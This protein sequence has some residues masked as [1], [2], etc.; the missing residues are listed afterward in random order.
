MK[1]GKGFG[2]IVSILLLLCLSIGAIGAYPGIYSQTVK[3]RK[4]YF[5]EENFTNQLVQ[6]S[7]A[8]YWKMEQQKADK[9]LLP[10]DVFMPD[11]TAPKK[12]EAYRQGVTYAGEYSAGYEDSEYYE[13]YDEYEEERAR[14]EYEAYD[15]YQSFNGWFRDIYETMGRNRGMQF[16]AQDHKTNQVLSNMKPSQRDALSP[17]TVLPEFD[18]QYQ[19]Y[20]WLTFDQKGEASISQVAGASLESQERLKAMDLE[21]LIYDYNWY[22]FMNYYGRMEGPKDMSLL[23]AVENDNNAYGSY[24]WYYG[25]WHERS[26]FY[27]AGFAWL[28]LGLCGL[29]LLLGLLLPII[30]PLRLGGGVSR[31][32]PLEL[33]AFGLLMVIPFSDPMVQMALSTASG[34]AYQDLLENSFLPGSANVL[35]FGGNLT[36][37]MLLL[38]AIYLMGLSLRQI[39]TMG[40]KAYLLKRCWCVRFVSWCCRKVKGLFSALG[41]VDLSEKSNKM[42]AK[43]VFANFLILTLI[44]CFWFFGVAGLVIYS[45]I[46]YVVLKSRLDEAKNSYQKLMDQIRRMK[47]G[48]LDASTDEDLG[49][50]EPMKQELSGLADGMARAVEV[51][52]ESQRTTS[53]MINHAADSL[54]EPLKD[55]VDSA[56]ALDGDHTPEEW[57]A[58]AAGVME[59]AA[60]L[61][62]VID[63]LKR[64]A[65]AA[66]KS[67]DVSLEPVDLGALLKQAEVELGDQATAAGIAL[68]IQ[69]P[70]EKV[71]LPLDS[72]KSYRVIEILFKNIIKHGQPG[73]RAYV[74][75][76]PMEDW[77]E[78]TLKNTSAKELDERAFGGEAGGLN[79]ALAK[80]LTELMDGAYQVSTDGDL[81]KTVLRFK[82]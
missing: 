37:W 14:A 5:E 55:L 2:V 27:Q 39:F 17:G 66:A 12:P 50:F 56:N 24:G 64:A 23:L 45:L 61:Q 49:V 73:S 13:Y 82:R 38:G 31:V 42:L 16:W 6:S 69:L 68:R 72:D 60:R 65:T 29:V 71:I 20:I 35:V 46:L 58:L 22:D 79:V 15:R 26:N 36:A 4:N 54:Q 57:K 34:A 67:G 59:K 63:S 11:Y 51:E 48:R 70:E 28:Y 7:Y 62:P 74:T 21:D 19:Y 75:V 25:Y 1:R 8:I 43:A 76:K 18:Q 77:V 10:T 41:Q 30:K 52:T 44:C 53:S 32:I 78:I 80:S 81:Y 47:T 9:E 40:P 3:M 33:C